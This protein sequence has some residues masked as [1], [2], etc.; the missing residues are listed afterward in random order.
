MEAIIN[1]VGLAVGSSAVTA[2]CVLAG[3]W[4]KAKYGEKSK[5]E[6]DPSPF[7]VQQQGPYVTTGEC[8]QHRC[9]IEKRIDILSAG[10]QKVLD[11]L[12]ELDQRSEERAIALNRRIDPMLEKLSATAATVDMLKTAAQK[13]TI[14]GRKQ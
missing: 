2:V 13:S 3:Q 1:D 9:A 7:P 4:I 12:D 14:G 6:P 5:I 8:K 10:N 11:K